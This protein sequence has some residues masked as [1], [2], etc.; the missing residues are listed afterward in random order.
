MSVFYPFVTGILRRRRETK[1]F[2]VDQLNAPVPGHS[3]TTAVGKWPWE[4]PARESD[5]EK[6]VSMIVD[7]LEKPSV[8][9][10]L[11]RL[12]LTGVSVQEITNTI[13]LGGFTKGEFSPDV[14]ELIKPA[15]VI[16]VTKIALDKEIPV[17][18]FN[19]DDKQ[20]EADDIEMLDA[21]KENNPQV[22]NRIMQM[23]D[24]EDAMPQIENKEP[25][26]FLDIDDS[27]VQS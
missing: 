12:M 18:V 10:R 3:L 11:A 2:N 22:F 1:D 5:P 6:V 23:K 15:I 16:Y 14:A 9:D 13:A 27:E 4:R 20:N 19:N 21:M 24:E 26:G 7:K 8:Q 17:K 25:R